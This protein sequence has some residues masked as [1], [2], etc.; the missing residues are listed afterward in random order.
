MQD[1]KSRNN[2]NYSRWRFGIYKF[3]YVI[4]KGSALFIHPN[5][6]L[7]NPGS[8]EIEARC[9]RYGF[10]LAGYQ[11]DVL[12][13]ESSRLND[14]DLFVVFVSSFDSLE[15]VYHLP[16][17]ANVIVVS[18]AENPRSLPVTLLSRLQDKKLK[19]YAR[20]LAEYASLVELFGSDTVI[21]G[22]QWFLRPF[23]HIDK[24]SQ[25][26]GNSEASGPRIL[27]MAEPDRAEGFDI[28]ERHGFAIDVYSEHEKKD[29]IR[30]HPCLGSSH[31]SFHKRLLYGSNRWYSK[32]NSSHAMFEP[33][34]RM[35]AS[36]LEKLWLG[37]N[38]ILHK[39]NP[40]LGEIRTSIDPNTFFED[41]VLIRMKSPKFLKQYHAD[42]VARHMLASS[43]KAV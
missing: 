19:Y 31:I 4:M 3:V 18:Y 22:R 20:S 12:S 15:T 13:I 41:F 25:T 8:G 24:D 16:E 42:Y 29:W 32:L 37:G 1:E 21:Q 36:V 38:V 43:L 34:R 27:V 17:G 14:Y 26:A 5:Q 33:N 7:I 35:T 30:Y 28:L 23:V 6:S 10:Q 11:T 9:L 40:A 2:D 39:D